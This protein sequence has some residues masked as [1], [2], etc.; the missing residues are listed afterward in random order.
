PP[1]T[2]NVIHGTRA[3]AEWIM[4]HPDVRAVSVFGSS[5]V[6][7]HVYTTAAAQGKRVQALGGA[8]NALIVMPDADLRSSVESITASA[9]GCAGQRCLAGSNVVAVGAI[10]EPLVRELA[11]T[12]SGLK[13]GFGLD[14]ATKMGP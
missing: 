6:A 7:K 4:A 1:G 10:A 11:T 8:K 9:F 12:A 13:M 5:P 3:V 14:P 2:F